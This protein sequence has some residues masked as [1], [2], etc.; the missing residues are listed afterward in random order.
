MMHQIMFDMAE[1]VVQL[2]FRIDM[3]DKKISGISRF[4]V[5]SSVHNFILSQYDDDL[6]FDHK[7]EF[8][9]RLF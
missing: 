1:K 3:N 7:M 9:F 6:F 2:N 4:H 5:F 8:N